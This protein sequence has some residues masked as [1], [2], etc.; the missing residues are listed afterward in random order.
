MSA[1]LHSIIRFL[2]I[3]IVVITVLPALASA[4]DTIEKVKPAIVGIGT[5]NKLKTPR[6]TLLGTGFVVSENLVATNAHVVP[7]SLEVKGSSIVIFKSVGSKNQYQSATVIARDRIH[8]LALLKVQNLK[9]SPLALSTQKVREGEIYLYTGFPIGAVLGLHP[10]THRGMISSITPVAIPA[11]N[12]KEL[13]LE[14]VKQLKKNPYKVYQIDG[15]AY[16]GNS[17]SP[18][19]DSESGN[20][21][22][23]IN[24]V[25]VKKT[26]ESALTDPSAITYAIPV[27][28]LRSLINSQ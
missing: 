28:H 5:Y 22:A 1:W 9:L 16:P 15:T 25:L 3:V 6:A 8:D 2:L 20:V 13:T 10:A 14:Q 27:E 19:Y 17:G 12:S 24:K 23:V 4:P 7:E 11:N 26:R 18:V 21:V